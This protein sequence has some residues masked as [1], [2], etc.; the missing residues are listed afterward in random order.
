[1]TDRPLFLA[2]K[3]APVS[4]APDP[5]TGALR[6]WLAPSGTGNVVAEQAG[7]LGVSWIASAD[8]DDDHRAAA[9]RLLDRDVDVASR[10]VRV[11]AQRVGSAHEVLGVDT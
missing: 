7:V 9:D 1:V 4:Y 3:R 10:G 11:R 5:D 2:S 8:T 6:P